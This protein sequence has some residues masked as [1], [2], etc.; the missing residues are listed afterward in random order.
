MSENDEI[1]APRRL[2]ADDAARIDSLEGMLETIANAVLEQQQGS[3]ADRQ[4]V[5]RSVAASE[6]S[7]RANEA[8]ARRLDELAAQQ[9]AILLPMAAIVTDVAARMGIV[10]KKTDKAARHAKRAAD[11][12]G[13]FPRQPEDPTAARLHG[14]H[15]ILD[16][17]DRAKPRTQVFL[18][19]VFFL[20][21]V[22]LLFAWLV[23]RAR[24]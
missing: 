13:S 15:R 1:T 10:I 4:L 19:V 11:N 18:S 23:E 3:A 14:V 22:G 17:I 16:R 21:T 24:H 9:E 7:A 12:T 2:A 8:T 6:R 20:T 5:E